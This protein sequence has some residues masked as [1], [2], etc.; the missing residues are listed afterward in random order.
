MMNTLSSAVIIILLHPLA[1]APPPHSLSHST[2]GHS[3]AN[4]TVT[5]AELLEDEG[6]GEGLGAYEVMA[7]YQQA[8]KYYLEEELHDQSCDCLL[9]VAKRAAKIGR[10]DLAAETFVT[11]AKVYVE[12][13]LLRPNTP[14]VFLKAALCHLANGGAISRGLTA[15]GTLRR[16]MREWCKIDY[17]FAHSREFALL[18]NLL[19]IIPAADVDAFADHVYSYDNV[20]GLDG[21]AL[22]LL[23]IV[24]RDI[25]DEID[26]R[27]REHDEPSPPM[28]E[29]GEGGT[30]DDDDGGGGDRNNEDPEQPEK[31]PIDD[32]G[33][34]GFYVLDDV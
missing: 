32:Y 29:S 3:A 31:E 1:A 15:H 2:T 33:D 6:L 14:Q 7:Y 22:A 23:N 19:E 25:E 4:L 18:E 13:N 17:A 10:F 27:A 9:E 5:I 34:D 30:G 26:R 11:V 21:W 12:S 20:A 24:K 28:G 16:A 8:S